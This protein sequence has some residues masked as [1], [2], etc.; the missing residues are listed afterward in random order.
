MYV[1]ISDISCEETKAGYRYEL[2]LKEDT[3]ESI[4]NTFVPELSKYG[5]PYKMIY[6]KCDEKFAY[7]EATPWSNFYILEMDFTSVEEITDN[8]VQ[9][10]DI[11]N[12][13]GHKVDSPTKGIYI[14]NGK[15]VLVK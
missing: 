14:I 2:L 3:M 8:R 5:I 9:S 4:V 6:I 12:L 1:N 10:T 13:Q 11:Y 15:K 7:E